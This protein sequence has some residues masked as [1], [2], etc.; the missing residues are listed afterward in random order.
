[1]RK[2]YRNINT[3]ELNTKFPTTTAQARMLTNIAYTYEQPSPGSIINY[4][5]AV[6]HYYLSLKA[7]VGYTP[8]LGLQRILIEK[9]IWMKQEQ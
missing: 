4:N 5:K 2:W 6:D 1:M 9:T 8:L 3:A 7:K